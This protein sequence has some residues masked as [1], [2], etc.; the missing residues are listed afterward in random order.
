MEKS[1][2]SL[3]S[4]SG[5]LVAY[6]IGF[7]GRQLVTLITLPLI[8]NLVSQEDFGIISIITSFYIVCNTIT[9]MGLP[10]ATFRFYNDK[11]DPNQQNEVLGT[12]QTLFFLL[13]FVLAV[14]IV[15]FSGTVSNLLLG[16]REYSLVIRLVALLVVVETMNY[17]GAILL[18]LHTRPG[19]FQRHS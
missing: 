4:L 14:I 8:T 16:S 13:A 7:V 6:G 3:L 11:Q 12:S 15:V 5:Q 17:Y 10:S 2:R 18:R 1:L 9:N 19:P